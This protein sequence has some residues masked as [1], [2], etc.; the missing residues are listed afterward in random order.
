MSFRGALLAIGGRDEQDNPTAAV[1]RYIPETNSWEVVSHMERR[2]YQCFAVV[3]P[4][5]CQ[6]MVVG[7]AIRKYPRFACTSEVEVTV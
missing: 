6:I 7:G 3:V 2:R 5:S 4:N 1:H